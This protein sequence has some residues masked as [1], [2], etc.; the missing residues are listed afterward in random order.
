L[1]DLDVH[2]LVGREAM[3]WTR[4]SKAARQR[5]RATS[6][7][8]WV[9]RVGN[10]MLSYHK[11]PKDATKWLAKHRPDSDIRELLDLGYKVTKAYTAEARYVGYDPEWIVEDAEDYEWAMNQLQGW[12]YRSWE[13]ERDN[14]PSP[15]GRATAWERWHDVQA[16]IRLSQL[17]LVREPAFSYDFGPMSP[18][19][20]KG[21]RLK[22]AVYPTPEARLQE[23]VVHRV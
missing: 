4:E 23:L 21:A 8:F 1:R 17:T 18:P 14:H 11:R 3:I 6:Q 20:G 19:E 13:Q 22:L 7:T 2:V 12:V 15:A 9:V 10:R 5:I 16:L